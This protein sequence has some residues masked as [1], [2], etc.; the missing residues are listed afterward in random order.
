[1]TRAA[2]ATQRSV[3][4]RRRGV[5]VAL[6]ALALPCP[7]RGP[8]GADGPQGRFGDDLIARLEGEWRVERAIRGTTVHNRARATWVLAHQF[9]QL[10]MKDVAEPPR[11]EALALIGYVHAERQHVAYR[12]DTCGA[13]YAAVGRGTRNGNST[14]FRFTYP[15]GPPYNTFTWLPDRQAWAMRKESVDADAARRLFALDTLS[16]AP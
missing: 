13:K 16:K 3:D 4:G 5:A 7:A 14:G 9:L 12:A 2:R 1:M 6:A 11:Y 10:H 15:D 8:S